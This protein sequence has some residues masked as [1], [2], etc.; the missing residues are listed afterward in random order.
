MI[1][2]ET[3]SELEAF[4]STVYCKR[5]LGYTYEPLILF[6]YGMLLAYTSEYIYY[7]MRKILHKQELH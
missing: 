2:I 5:F 7:P 1:Q 6:A 3:S 4:I